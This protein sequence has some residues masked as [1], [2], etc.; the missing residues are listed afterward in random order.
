MR[1]QIQIVGVQFSSFTR[2]VQF[3]CEEIGLDYTLGVMVDNQEYS[4][5]SPALTTINPF[6][7]VPVL[8]DAGRPL[9]E[10]QTICR[11]LDNQYNK[12]RLQPQDLWQRAQVDQ[13]CAAITAYVDRAIVR[14]YLLEFL[15]PKGVN[16]TVREDVVAASMP[17]VIQVVNLL[18]QQL[19]EKNFLVGDQL[20]VA[21]ILVTPILAYLMTAPHH[22]DLVNKDSVLRSYVARMLAR[23]AAKNV[24]IPVVK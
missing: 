16:G 19:G 15:F 4:L 8:L 10:T 5:R 18:E 13:W 21:D 1:H 9:Y 22:L 24:F 2:A 20:T 14:N 17:E 11:Y 7:K 3:C 6:S 23:P 12:S